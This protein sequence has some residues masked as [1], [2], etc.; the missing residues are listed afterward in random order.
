MV[1]IPLLTPQFT[2]S[3]HELE[4]VTTTAVS[5]VSQTFFMAYFGVQ[6]AVRFP[7]NADELHHLAMKDDHTTLCFHFTT[8]S[9]N[10]V[11]K[12][13]VLIHKTRV[14]GNKAWNGKICQNSQ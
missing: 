6:L 11:L 5:M 9:V 7:F 13:V 3:Y 12:R 4:C 2:L 14:V 8:V 10:V 1:V